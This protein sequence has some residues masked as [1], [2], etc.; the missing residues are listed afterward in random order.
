DLSAQADTLRR[1]IGNLSTELT[2]ARAQISQLEREKSEL[3]AALDREIA[4]LKDA[5]TQLRQ[6]L[7]DE[8]DRG[9]I[10]VNRIENVLIVSLK[11]QILFEPDRAELNP[12][13]EKP[14]LEIARIF[15][16][17]PEKVIRIEGHTAV[18]PTRWPSSWDLGA[19][20]AVT[21]VRFLQEKGRI[22]PLRLVA[23][24]FG[25]Y[26]PI[27]PNDTEQNRQKNRRVELILINRPL[28]EVQSLRQAGV[29]R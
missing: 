27:S 24:S 5:E 9:T 8:I 28:Y 19:A 25:E 20:R 2:R 4:R 22:D 23:A 6:A 17:L 26:R 13:F 7:K 18:A 15:D 14:L 3:Q 11:E 12:R 29:V 16:R 10:E 21:V 1:E